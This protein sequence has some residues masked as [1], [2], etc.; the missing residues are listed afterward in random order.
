MMLSLLIMEMMLYMAEMVLIS[1]MEKKVLTFW[2]VVQ[3]MIF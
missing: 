3:G 1:F 2:L